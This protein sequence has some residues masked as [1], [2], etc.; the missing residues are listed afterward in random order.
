MILDEGICCFRWLHD[1]LLC[2][3]RQRVHRQEWPHSAGTQQY[4]CKACG[5]HRVLAP[6][7]RCATPERQA[8]ILRAVEVEHLSLRAAECVFRVARKTV[9]GWL[10]KKPRA[11]RP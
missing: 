4:L 8:E 11:C 10:E 7:S 5:A 6:K 3:M 1:A 9:I 2:E